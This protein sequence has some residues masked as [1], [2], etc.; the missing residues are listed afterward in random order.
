M[1]INLTVTPSAL[2]HLQENMVDSPEGTVGIRIGLRDAGCSG[3]AYT[4]DFTTEHNPDDQLHVFE[5]I[6]ILIADKYAQFFNGTE[7]DLVQ[8]GVN[9]ILEFNNPNVAHE[10]GCGESFKFEDSE[11]ED[12]ESCAD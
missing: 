11:H 6:K 12:I 10:C 1:A 3:F 4:M 5:D 2:Q 9:S 8:E 7:I